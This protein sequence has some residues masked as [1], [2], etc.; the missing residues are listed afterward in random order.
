MIEYCFDI[1][2]SKRL[3]S[4]LQ[5]S[6]EKLKK[7]STEILTSQE[8]ERQ[9]VA[10]DLHDGVVQT[11]MASK[12]NLRAYKEDSHRSSD[13]FGMG[14]EFIDNAIKE[15]KEIYTGLYPSILRDIGL[16][17][18]VRWYAKNSLEI[19]GIRVNLKLKIKKITHHVIEI[20]LYRIIQ[21]LFSNV[22]KHSN[23]DCVTVELLRGKNGD[24][25]LIVE[26]NGS[27][28]QAEEIDSIKYGYGLE[29]IRHRADSLNGSFEIKSSPGNGTRIMITVPTGEN[30]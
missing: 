30:P 24:I 9:R 27:G 3:L 25:L 12:I 20:N 6:K 17:A 2:E 7:L 22:L 19:E 11:L 1:T 15:L 21:E 4:A 28:F 8:R 23:A 26:D 14:L 13:R 10:K 16:H 18:A 5:E 29:N